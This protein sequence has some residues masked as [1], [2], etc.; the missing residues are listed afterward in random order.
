M[1]IKNIEEKT[2]AGEIE[3]QERPNREERTET[4]EREKNIRHKEKLGI[5]SGTMHT[6][7]ESEISK[8]ANCEYQQ[9][10]FMENAGYRLVLL[11][12]NKRKKQQQKWTCPKARQRLFVHRLRSLCL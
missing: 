9:L 10:N 12:K 11:K 5:T 7:G 4:R 8:S 2:K 3:R 6:T 1:N